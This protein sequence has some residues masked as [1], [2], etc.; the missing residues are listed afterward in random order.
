MPPGALLTTTTG[1]EAA[2]TGGSPSS[3]RGPAASG[4]PSGWSSPGRRD[5][6]LFEA[7]RRR[8]RHLAEQHL[9][10]RGL[11]RAVAPLLLLLRPQARLDQDLRRPARDPALLRGL[12]R[13]LRHR[14]PPAHRHPH[15]G[16]PLGRGG[17]PLAADRRRRAVPTR[18]TCWSAPS[19]P[20]PR[21]RCPTSTGCDSFAGPCFH[22]ARWEHEHDL[23]GR[24]VAVI[25]T[26]A[27]RGADRARAGQGGARTVDVFQRTPQWILPRS[28]KPFTEEEKRRFARNPIGHA[29]APRGDLLGLREH[30]RLPP[31]R[32][33]GRAARG[34]LRSA[35]SSTGSRTTS[36]GPS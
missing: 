23:A 29:P 8:R 2:R 5:F 15:H 31:R 13:P 16:G 28:D 14:P 25:G 19:G 9:P 36:C 18:P 17:A 27:E 20:S 33:R 6:V 30:H 35:T 7:L 22:S 1:G 3:G 24:R 12:R 21:R 10:R 4:W 26:G 34:D 32:R 11:R